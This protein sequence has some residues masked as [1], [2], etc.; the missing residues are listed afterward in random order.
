MSRG[1]GLVHGQLEAEVVLL[2]VGCMGRV[3]R[4][5]GGKLSFGFGMERDF[6]EGVTRR[7]CPR[8]KQNQR[9]T[10]RRRGY[11]S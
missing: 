6:A 7:V 1:V 4:R 8:P 5:R 3:E 11:H 2:G 9:R 10:I